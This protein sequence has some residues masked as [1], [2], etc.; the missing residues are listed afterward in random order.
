MLEQDIINAGYKYNPE[1][2]NNLDEG[3]IKIGADRVEYYKELDEDTW[4][5]V[6]SDLEGNMMEYQQIKKG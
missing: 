2:A 6:C 3:Y 5:Y 4:F 1:G